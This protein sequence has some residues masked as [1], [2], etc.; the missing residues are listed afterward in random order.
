VTYYFLPQIPG[1]KCKVTIANFPCVE[2]FVKWPLRQHVYVTWSDGQQWRVKRIGALEP[3][4]MNIFTE[5]EL[6]KFDSRTAGSFVFLW[7][8][9]LPDTMDSLISSEHMETV[10]AWRA[11]MQ[12]V[13]S[14]TSV[15][16]Q[17]DYPRQ[18]VELEKGSLFSFGPLFQTGLGISTKLILVNLRRSPIITSHVLRLARFGARKALGKVTIYSNAC[19]I[20]N[21]SEFCDQNNTPLSLLC[22]DLAG[23]PIYLSHDP[24]FVNMSL[25]HTHQPAELFMFG[26][27]HV[28]QRRLKSWWLQTGR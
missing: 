3:G 14:S 27:R 18:M 9:V 24:C 5:D 22:D 19:N 26:A 6:S 10:P 21:L 8:E 2:G 11:N 7:P 12:L 20:V 4:E 25:E 1:L 13:S 16:Y 15:S 28:V 17:G 23:I